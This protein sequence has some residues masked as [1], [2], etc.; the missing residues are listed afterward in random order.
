MFFER[1]VE[2]VAFV[3]A[4]SRFLS[5]PA[6][7]PHLSRPD[8]VE[9]RSH[10]AGGGQLELYLSAPALE[11]AIAAFSPVPAAE[12]VLSDALPKA[13]ELLIQGSAPAWGLDEAQSHLTKRWS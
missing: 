10:R 6:G 4:L 2:G 9:V 7:A 13:C 8:A 12:A 5:S 11:A 3:A 1:Q